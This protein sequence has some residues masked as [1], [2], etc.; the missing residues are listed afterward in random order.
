[1]L[2]PPQADG[3]ITENGVT[4]DNVELARY[5][6]TEKVASVA[7]TFCQSYKGWASHFLGDY[8]ACLRV[9]HTGLRLAPRHKKAEFRNGIR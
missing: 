9:H 8:E 6:I 4:R 2:P 5:S 1:M 7:F 3:L